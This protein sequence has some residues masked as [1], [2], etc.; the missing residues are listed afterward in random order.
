MS[1]YVFVDNS[2]VWIEGKYVSG[3]IK[4]LAQSLEEAHNN[5]IQDNSWTID[6]G[7]LLYCVTETN[8][9]DISEA[10]LIGSKPTDKD[11]LWNAMEKAGFTVVNKS[12]NAAN[13]EKQIDTG[14]VSVICK[15]LY[16]NAKPGDTFVLVMGDSDY[17]PVVKDIK[18]EHINVVVA[19]WDHASSEL[20]S[21]SDKFISLNEII[22]KIT[23]SNK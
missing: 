12:R 10:V 13:K 5:K 6:F 15:Y 18:D 22:D 9:S 19:F 14:I 3:I 4:G 17:V 2:N 16:K 23:Y 20:K 8:I 21:R 7:K 1:Y 11:S